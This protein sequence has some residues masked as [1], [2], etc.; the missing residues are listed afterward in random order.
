MVLKRLRD[1]AL[2]TIHEGLDALENPVAMLNQYLRD[3]EAEI[4]K[5][6]ASIVKQIMIEK[7][8]W[9]YRDEA[10]R[11]VEKR[12]RQAALAVEAGEE[13]LARRALY[14]KKQ[15]AQ[16]VEQYERMAKE[17][18][19][20]V[21]EMKEQL[22]EMKEKYTAMRDRKYELISRAHAAKS[23]KQMQTALSKFDADSALKGFKRM[24]ERIMEMETELEIRK[25]GRPLSFEERLASL[26]P[27]EEIEKELAQL[28][29]KGDTS[30]S[31]KS[32]SASPADKTKE[33]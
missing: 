16:K 4:E 28:K 25:E 2:A 11:M 27:D 30:E 32:S 31:K 12:Q 8:F 22:K 29:Q 7:K 20:K 26:E 21:L 5:A 15:Y 17:A 1:I 6:E 9:E 19:Q 10:Q 18:Q 24:E 13:D 23:K 3:M 33:A 14:E